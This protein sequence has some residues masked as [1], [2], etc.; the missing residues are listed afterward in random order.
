MSREFVNTQFIYKKNETL[1]TYNSE[2]LLKHQWKFAF[3]K[4]YKHFPCISYVCDFGSPHKKYKFRFRC[5]VLFFFFFF[6]FFCSEG[7]S[8]YK[9]SSRY[10]LPYKRRYAWNF[11]IRIY[12][13]RRS[14]YIDLLRHM[15]FFIKNYDLKSYNSE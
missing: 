13:E 8:D 11:A 1:K 4:N 2:Q 3:L 7:T 15:H 9:S 14:S 12:A 5:H 10:T 6:F